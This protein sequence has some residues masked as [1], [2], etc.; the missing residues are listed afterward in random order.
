MD[1]KEN[2]IQVIPRGFQEIDCLGI[3]KLHENQVSNKNCEKVH[4]TIKIEPTCNS[5]L[6]VH[7]SPSN[8]LYFAMGVKT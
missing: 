7:N 3:G 1:G 6:L 8:P 2:L 4:V 5:Y